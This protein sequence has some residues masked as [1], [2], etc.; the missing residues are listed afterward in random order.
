M[1]VLQGHEA[2]LL[3]LLAHDLEEVQRCHL[4]GTKQEGLLGGGVLDVCPARFLGRRMRAG[5][6]R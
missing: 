3:Q 5:R 2:R 4:N 6:E 1:C